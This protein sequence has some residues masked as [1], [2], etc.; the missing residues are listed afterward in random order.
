MGAGKWMMGARGVNGSAWRDAAPPM[1]CRTP[2]PALQTIAIMV[3]SISNGLPQLGKTF[4]VVGFT[5]LGRCS[6]K[7]PLTKLRGFA[8][9]RFKV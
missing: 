8:S 3:K 4:P 9:A 1:A 6:I 5:S 7:Q 2:T